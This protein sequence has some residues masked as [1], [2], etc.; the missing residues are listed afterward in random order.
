MNHGERINLRLRPPGDISGFYEYDQLVLVML[1]EVGPSFLGISNYMDQ[2]ADFGQL[3]HIEH[4]PH[5]AKFY[6]L[7]GEL[8]EEYYELKRK[9]YSGPFSSSQSPASFLL[10]KE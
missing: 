10:T 3:T 8:E 4:G 5:D 7:L 6:K 1:H 2:S 9:G